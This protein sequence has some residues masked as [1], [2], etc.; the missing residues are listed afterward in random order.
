[1]VTMIGLYLLLSVFQLKGSLTF[2]KTRFFFFPTFGSKNKFSP[3]FDT[4]NVSFDWEERVRG[5][6]AET[7][8]WKIEKKEKKGTKFNWTLKLSTFWQSQILGLSRGSFQSQAIAKWLA[9]TLNISLLRLLNL[10][11][12]NWLPKRDTKWSKV[13]GPSKE[14]GSSGYVS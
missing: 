2:L 3:F 11:F 4:Q 7:S 8:S 10:P 5:T 12:L 13:W 1:M 14:K 6:D 9:K